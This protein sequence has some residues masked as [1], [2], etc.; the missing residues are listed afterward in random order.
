MARGFVQEASA[1]RSE[2]PG[3]AGWRDIF[4]GHLIK[5]LGK[6]EGYWRTDL[7][8]NG[9]EGGGGV[10]GGDWRAL[11]GEVRVVIRTPREERR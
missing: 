3:T 6:S 8:N 2:A 11:V 10:H 4:G 9:I 7:G 1:D 5:R